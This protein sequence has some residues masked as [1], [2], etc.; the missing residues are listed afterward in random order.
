ML[1][2]TPKQRVIRG[3]LQRE[4]NQGEE[5]CSLRYSLEEKRTTRRKTQRRQEMVER[6]KEDKRSEEDERKQEFQ[7]KEESEEGAR[8]WERSFERKWEEKMTDLEIILIE[9]IGKGLCSRKINK[10][11]KCE[12]CRFVKE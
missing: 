4:L 1:K 6:V 9:E 7:G 12:N 10:G 2:G 3:N 11:Q 5:S 8:T